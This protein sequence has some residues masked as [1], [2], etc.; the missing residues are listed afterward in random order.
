MNEWGVHPLFTRIPRNLEECEYGDT[1]KRIAMAFGALASLV[2]LSGCVND[3]YG[4][5]YGYNGNGY[6]YGYAY[7]QGY[8]QGYYGRGYNGNYRN[9][10][11]NRYGRDYRRYDR[12]R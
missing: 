7:G 2:L 10:D 6:G 8:G 4:A 11:S 12:Y 5:G 1:M 3:G 9:Y